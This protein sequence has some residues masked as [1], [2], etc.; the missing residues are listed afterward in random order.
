MTAR[1]ALLLILGFTTACA[2]TCVPRS[3]FDP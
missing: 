3:D 1:I 2:A